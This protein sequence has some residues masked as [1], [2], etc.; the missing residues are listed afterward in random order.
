MSSARQSLV[1]Q[2]AWLPTLARDAHESISIVIDVLRAATSL[3]V[4][5]ETGIAEVL[6]APDPPSARSI[7]RTL[8]GSPLLCG[9]SEGIKPDDFDR[10]N[11]PDSFRDPSLRGRPVVFCSSNGA[12]AIHQVAG[13]GVLLI[14]A[15]VNARRVARSVVDTWKRQQRRVLVVCSGD[16]FGQRISLEDAYCAGVIVSHILALTADIIADVAIELD[17]GAVAALR[18]FQSYRSNDAPGG[19]PRSSATARMFAESAAARKLRAW[20]LDADV[21]A[22]GAV[23][24]IHGLMAVS[25]IGDRLVG[26]PV[27]VLD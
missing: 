12:G 21:Q 26:R 2:V 19:R 27:L 5:A 17:D 7:A 24:G 1:V 10:G 13:A 11:S 9:E 6:I 23:D 4:M 25:R 8:D 3:S 14:G 18:L 15:L 16:H 20:G 22:C